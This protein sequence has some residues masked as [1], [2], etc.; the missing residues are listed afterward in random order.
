MRKIKGNGLFDG[1]TLKVV[2]KNAVKEI[3]D[4]KMMISQIMR[5]IRH[6]E[7]K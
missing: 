1:Q 4:V 5:F 2:F 6:N 3:T 7:T